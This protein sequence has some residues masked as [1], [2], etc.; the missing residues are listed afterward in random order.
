MISPK[1]LSKVNSDLISPIAM[2]AR[3]GVASVGYSKFKI[4]KLTDNKLKNSDKRSVTTFN[5]ARRIDPIELDPT[6]QK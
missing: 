5:T 6:L 2:D 1:Y 3:Y 4:K